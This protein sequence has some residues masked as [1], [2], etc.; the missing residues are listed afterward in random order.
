MGFPTKP[1]TDGVSPRALIG[2]LGQPGDFASALVLEELG[3]ALAHDVKQPLSAIG[4]EAAACGNWLAAAPSDLS[5]VLASLRAIGDDARRA[6]E[7]VDRAQRLL[8]PVEPTTAC[9]LDALVE[10]VALALRPRMHERGLTL[11]SALGAA[12]G[13]VH[14]DAEPLRQVVTSLLLCAAD[15]CQSAPLGRRVITL[16]TRLCGRAPL[17]LIELRLEQT[18]ARI[19]DAPRGLL[20][21]LSSTHLGAV[22]LAL[23]RSIVE[24]HGGRLQLLDTAPQGTTFRMLLPASAEPGARED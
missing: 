24:R 15:A 9:A 8:A 5:R 20:E 1:G 19:E 14:L 12:G 16:R 17:T 21:V 4:A 11:T 6:S 7:L 3:N 18:G 23:C 2:Q 10:E 22:K 13:R